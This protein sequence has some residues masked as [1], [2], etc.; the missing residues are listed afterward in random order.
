MNS[1]P[2]LIKVRAERAKWDPNSL[3]IFA[4]DWEEVE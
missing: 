2:S 1:E 3:E 4:E